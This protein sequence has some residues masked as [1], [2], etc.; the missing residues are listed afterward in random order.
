MRGRKCGRMTRM[1]GSSAQDRY[2]GRV[3]GLRI[4]LADVLPPEAFAQADALIEHGEPAEGVGYLAW[5]LHNADVKGLE[6]AIGEVQ[7]L[8]EGLVDP[9]HLPPEFRPAH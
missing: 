1:S 5:A 8:T 3:N 7:E 6:W 4:A 9:E 2:L